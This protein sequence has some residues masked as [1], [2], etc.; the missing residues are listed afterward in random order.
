MPSQVTVSTIADAA[1]EAKVDRRL[2][3]D[4]RLVTAVKTL[5]SI[6]PVAGL[7]E[8]LEHK[9]FAVPVVGGNG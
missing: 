4:G 9:T 3:I 2:L 6:N 7:A 1:P 8:F 5:P